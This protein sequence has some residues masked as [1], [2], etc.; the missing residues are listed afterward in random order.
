V[1]PVAVTD[2]TVTNNKYAVLRATTPG[3]SP[4][5]R[6]AYDWDSAASSVVIPQ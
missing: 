1:V 3:G 5:V 4:D 6:V 2:F